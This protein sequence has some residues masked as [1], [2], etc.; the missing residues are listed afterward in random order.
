[1]INY[2]LVKNPKV[3]N[4]IYLFTS[5]NLIKYKYVNDLG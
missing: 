2:A 3:I 1:M 4:G 5:T